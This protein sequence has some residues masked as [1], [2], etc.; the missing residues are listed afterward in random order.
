MSDETIELVL[1]GDPKGQ[2]RPKR[3]TLKNGA[4]LMHSPKTEW[5]LG[6]KLLA[7]QHPPFTTDKHLPLY[8]EIICYFRRPGSHFRKDGS[9]K[10]KAP[11]RYTS[12]PDRDNLDKAV[13]DAL[14][15]GGL[16]PADAAVCDGPVRK[17]Y[18]PEGD[19]APKTVIRLRKA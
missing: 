9:L 10:P 13:C 8:V 2:G 17:F 16:I 1:P 15:Q 11:M 7:S 12:K 14:E 4:Q 3:F 19:N 5:Q 6:L 18:A